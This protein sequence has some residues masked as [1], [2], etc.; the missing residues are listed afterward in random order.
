MNMP[1]SPEQFAEIRERTR[2]LILDKAL[3][4]FARKGY[5]STSISQIAKAAGMAKG[6]LYHYFENKQ[7]L[8]MA[9]VEESL[10]KVMPLLHQP[11][12]DSAEELLYN[13]FFNLLQAIQQHRE[14]WKLYFSLATQGDLILEMSHLLKPLQEHNVLD[15]SQQLGRF[16][17][18]LNEEDFIMI[19]A[20]VKG[21]AMHLLFL[22][23]ETPNLERLAQRMT[24][25]VLRG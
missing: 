25:A 6:A 10:E 22:E 13:F 17:L 11:E 7:A 12:A 20:M 5:H 24:S 9:I 8:F 19:S 3:A 21:M 16:S 1:K 15:I 18:S 2:Q 23:A 4:L 14:F